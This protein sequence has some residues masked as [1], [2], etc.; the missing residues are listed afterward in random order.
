MRFA[1]VCY[2]AHDPRWSF[3]P[4]SGEG[5]AITG[6]RFNRKG[7]PALYTS[8]E[9]GTAVAEC[10]QGLAHRV[11][12]MTI[13]QYDVDCEPVADLG[14]DSA[15]ASL[16]VTLA[17]L[18]CAWLSEM[19]SGREPSSWLVADRLKAAGY[20][21]MLAPSFAPSV[22]ATQHN[23]ILWRWGPDLPTRIVAYDPDGRLPRDQSS[24]KT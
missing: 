14:N 15:R 8:L 2:R 9:I 24:W 13:C 6:G 18:A 22:V 7:E 3:A 20:A 17:E 10:S 21:G 23:L 19:L 1:G 12:P 11:P 4:L 16:G 5:A